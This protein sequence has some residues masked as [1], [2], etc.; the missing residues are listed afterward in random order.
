MDKIETQ[1]KFVAALAVLMILSALVE[2]AVVPAM[3]MDDSPGALPWR[4]ASGALIGVVLHLYLAFW[5]GIRLRR[6][7]VEIRNEIYILAAIGL[8][9]LGFMI[10][11]GAYA[12]QEESQ[13]V[14]LMMLI[15]AIIDFAA[16][17]VSVLALIFLRSKK[18]D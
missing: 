3:L 4:A 7:K 6:R 2:L 13:F 1:K 10:L 8:F 15:C 18:K 12:F 16:T 9:F 14:Y 17:L 11:D 5:F